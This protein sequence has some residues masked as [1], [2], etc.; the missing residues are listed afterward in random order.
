MGV[1][2]IASSTVQANDLPVGNLGESGKAPNS[3]KSVKIDKCSDWYANPLGNLGRL[4]G[5]NYDQLFASK[6][7]GDKITY[8]LETVSLKD[9]KSKAKFSMKM[10][11][12]N[13]VLYSTP[14]EGPGISLVKY[15]KNDD[16]CFDGLAS[17]TAISLAEGQG[18]KRS[19]AI[20]K[21]AGRYTSYA[22]KDSYAVMDRVQKDSIRFQFQ[23][24]I[25]KYSNINVRKGERIIYSNSLGGVKGYYALVRD[26]D[27]KSIVKYAAN[28][29]KEKQLKLKQGDRIARSGEE[30]V[31]IR[32]SS[33]SNF[34]YFLE[35]KEWSKAKKT[36]VYKVD[37]PQGLSPKQANIN[38]SSKQQ[39]M[40]I[41]SGTKFFKD[42]YNGVVVYDYGNEKILSR[43]DLPKG[44]IPGE[45][46]YSFDGKY[47]V[48]EEISSKTGVRKALHIFYLTRL[49]WKKI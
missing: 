32:P 26:G 22:Y 33:K 45:V 17:I 4:N 35:N 42:R 24:F 2:C 49:I 21:D 37:L 31:I 40:F 44:S 19:L 38:F 15:A 23:P 39:V 1:V 36:K 16:G 41:S 29:E 10:P 43:L 46:H 11:E 3:I 14:E 18:K 27:N 25:K 30:F 47:G 7:D 28:G 34:L 9:Q 48:V 5:D 20:L 12:I 13:Q 6:L 8:V